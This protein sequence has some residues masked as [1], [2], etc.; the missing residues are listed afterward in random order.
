MLEA[1]YVLL[2]NRYAIWLASLERSIR[3]ES[4]FMGFLSGEFDGP[5]ETHY[6]ATSSEDEQTPE[7]HA[8][9]FETCA[10]S[11][12]RTDQ[13]DTSQVGSLSKSIGRI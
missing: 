6:C 1:R 9:L 5:I 8:W 7:K 10:H 11:E 12:R 4:L 3:Q 2:S 13:P